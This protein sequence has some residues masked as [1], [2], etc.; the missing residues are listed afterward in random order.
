MYLDPRMLTPTGIVNPVGPFHPIAAWRTDLFDD[1]NGRSV[2]DAY[3][4]VWV[5]SPS[6]LV[7][8]VYFGRVEVPVALNY[9]QAEVVYEQ[10]DAL[11]A[12]R[13]EAAIVD[14]QRG[15]AESERA[16]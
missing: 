5:W 7:A 13:I 11:D 15:L 3:D 4:L 2:T 6:S 9:W 14:H 16:T 12:H 8:R 10:A 1:A